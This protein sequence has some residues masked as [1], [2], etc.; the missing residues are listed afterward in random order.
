LQS[1]IRKPETDYY[2][3]TS[4]FNPADNIAHSKQTP[5]IP[6]QLQGLCRWG[7][8]MQAR[9]EEKLRLHYGLTPDGQEI[10]PTLLQ[11]QPLDKRSYT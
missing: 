3:V 4:W 5:A 10:E 6:A 1:G 2:L 11:Y 9:I 7:L 8:T